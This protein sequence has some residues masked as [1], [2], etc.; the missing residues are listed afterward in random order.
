MKPYLLILIPLT[1]D[2]RA[3]IDAS[4]SERFEILYAPTRNERTEAVERHGAGVQIVLTNGSTGLTGD[5]IAKM[6]SLEFISAL[7]AGYEHI[8]VDAAQPRGI[9]VVNGAGTNA[10]CVADHAFALLLAAV[11]E[12]PRLDRVAREGVWRDG[13]KE[14]PQIAGKRLGVVGLG[15][16]GRKVARRA[17]GFDMETGYHNR[18]PKPDTTSRYFDSVLAL[19]EWSDALVVATPGG[20]ATHHLID[21]GVLAALGPKGYLVNVSRGSVVDTAALVDA[22]ERGA[23]AGAGIDVFEEEPPPVDLRLLHLDNVVVTPHIG[24]RS[25]DAI[26]ASVR[27]FIEN[28]TRHLNGDAVLTPV[29]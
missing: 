21:A 8:A 20:A 11:R 24:G 28:L 2:S 25:P 26:A 13:L 17:A 9:V 1:D 15:H 12:I 6:P 23:I 3:T 5:E 7:G 29:G 14:Q 10:D 27:H 18:K 22:L 4:L 19:A 16:I